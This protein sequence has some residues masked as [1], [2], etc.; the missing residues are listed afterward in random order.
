MARGSKG[1]QQLISLGCDGCR[2]RLRA[3][4][5]QQP[6]A[7]AATDPA[8]L[9]VAVAGELLAAGGGRK[10][11]VELFLLH[12]STACTAD[13][14]GGS[15]ATTYTVVC[16]MLHLLPPPSRGAAWPAQDPPDAAPTRAAG[17][18]GGDEG[19]DA[20]GRRPAAATVRTSRA[21]HCSGPGPTR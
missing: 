20:G 10:G 11:F 16:D 6:V 17:C 13:A 21:V 1:I 19:G 8:A 9:I 2:F 15:G 4:H 5:C 7:T 18:A 3:V 12:G 14:H